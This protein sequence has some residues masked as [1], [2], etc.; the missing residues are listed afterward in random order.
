VD[1]IP[2]L[3]ATGFWRHAFGPVEPWILILWADEKTE[4]GPNEVE[5][6]S[7]TVVSL[8]CRWN[9]SA[10]FALEVKAENLWDETYFPVADGQAVPAMGRRAGLTARFAF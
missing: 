6:E 10:A 9:V 7:Y 2:V 8:G 3:R 1:D 4:P 5:R